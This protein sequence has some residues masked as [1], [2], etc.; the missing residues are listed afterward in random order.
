[1]FMVLKDNGIR[2]YSEKQ[3]PLTHPSLSSKDS[4]LSILNFSSFS[5]IFFTFWSCLFSVVKNEDLVSYYLPSPTPTL[6]FFTSSQ[7][8]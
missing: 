6:P 7:Y 2:V 5:L 8:S 3:G 4:P 1:M